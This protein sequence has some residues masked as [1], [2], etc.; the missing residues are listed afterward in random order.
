MHKVQIQVLTNQGENARFAIA[1]AV[2]SYMRS[3]IA[4]CPVK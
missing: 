3:Y 1:I 2:H 4:T